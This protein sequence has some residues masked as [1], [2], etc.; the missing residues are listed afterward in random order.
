MKKLLTVALCVLAS[1]AYGWDYLHSANG[2]Y[3][4]TW[5]YTNQ[6]LYIE[7]VVSMCGSLQAVNTQ[8]VT[9]AVGNPGVTNSYTFGIT[10]QWAASTSLQ[11]LLPGATLTFSDDSIITIT[12][13]PTVIIKSFR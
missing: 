9:V 3:T 6:S 5:T 4:N 13:Y 10:N 2:S 1:C 11:Y 7:E 8:I 12:N